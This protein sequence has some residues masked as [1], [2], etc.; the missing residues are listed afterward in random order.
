MKLAVIGCKV[1]EL[2]LRP[3]LPPDVEYRVMEQGL[4]RSPKLLRENLQAEIDSIDADEILLAYGQCGNGVVGL[5]SSRARLVVPKSDDCIALL[6]GSFDHYRQEVEKEPGTYW[7]SHGWIEESK[8]PY[9]EYLR[10]AEKYGE[11]TARW[12]ADECMKGYH[13]VVV[14]DTGVCPT[15]QLREYGQQ[16]AKFFNLDYTEIVGSDAFFQQLLSSEKRDGQFV[17]VEPGE[18]IT[19]E[20]FPSALGSVNG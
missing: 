13:R 16:F 4:H 2:E 7:F 6:L 10:C 14:I 11:E 9:K 20:M 8:D 3:L 18:T 15:S 5:C 12:V 1:M 19:S 17:V